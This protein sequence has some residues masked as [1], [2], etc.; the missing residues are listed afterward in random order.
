MLRSHDRK[1]V[2]KIVLLIYTVHSA[3]HFKLLNIQL[4]YFV[5]DANVDKACQNV[6]TLK[7]TTQNRVL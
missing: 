6:S 3:M 1:H 5:G 4:V 2:R 7:K